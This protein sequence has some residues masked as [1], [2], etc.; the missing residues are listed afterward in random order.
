MIEAIIVAAALVTLFAALVYV[1]RVYGDQ[2]RIMRAASASA[3]GY[4]MQ[5]CQGG[6]HLAD[7]LAPD[8]AQSLSS[9]P[10][11]SEANGGDPTSSL[12][13]GANSQSQSALSTVTR[14]GLPKQT[15]VA[16][17]Q[18]VSGPFGAPSASLVSA[19]ELV[20]CNDVEHTSDPIGL[21][22]ELKQFLF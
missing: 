5:G 12:P 7:F 2:A 19:S 21:F 14:F 16:G 10:T 17:Q 3:L 4:A 18:D 22:Q 6:A 20:L 11:A 9:D 13:P 8:D 15:F 1:H